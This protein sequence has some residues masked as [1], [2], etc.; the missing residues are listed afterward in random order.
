MT[1]RHQIVS[2]VLLLAGVGL[3][4][5]G[6][7]SA[8][9]FSLPGIIA[10]V[11]TIAGLLYAGSVWFGGGAPS[12]PSVLIFDRHLII[13]SGAHPGRPVGDL[14]PLGVRRDVEQRCRDAF[15]GRSTRFS[16]PGDAPR[17]RF[18]VAPIRTAD[19][20]VAYGILLSGAMVPLISQEQ[21]TPVA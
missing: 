4:F 2:T 9:N 5:A 7:S 12:E 17:R 8:L 14:F 18:E 19:G 6:M 10:T 20:L 21:L 11:A 13:V 1:Q 15:D 3:V 16:I